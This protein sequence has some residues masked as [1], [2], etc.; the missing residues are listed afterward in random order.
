MAAAVRA[1][2][3]DSFR[4]SWSLGFGRW[5]AHRAPRIS[6]AAKA[7]EALPRRTKGGGMA[8]EAALVEVC[9]GAERAWKGGKSLESYYSCVALGR[10]NGNLPQIGI[11]QFKY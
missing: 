5:E 6:G 8:K 11:V 9:D 2:R 3:W 1:F 7:G 10:H 4:F